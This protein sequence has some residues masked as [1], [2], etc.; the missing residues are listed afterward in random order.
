MVHAVQ[1]FGAFRNTARRDAVS[2]N[3]QTRLAQNVPAGEV[4][5]IDSVSVTGDPCV[6]LTVR[7]NTL[8]EADSFWTDLQAA[9][10]TGVNGPVVGSH[11]TRHDCGHDQLNPAPCVIATRVDW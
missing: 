7:F 4:T 11:A 9:L 3:I 5:R 6:S 8:A 10:G 2:Q 1:F